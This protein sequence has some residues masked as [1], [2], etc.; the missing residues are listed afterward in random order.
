MKARSDKTYRSRYPALYL[1]T[2]Q[3]SQLYFKRSFCSQKHETRFEIA[4]INI[5]PRSKDASLP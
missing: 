4:K 3:I 2:D 5:A 1:V